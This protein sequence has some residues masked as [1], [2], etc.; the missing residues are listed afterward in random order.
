M[1]CANAQRY[2]LCILSASVL[3]TTAV[4]REGSMPCMILKKIKHTGAINDTVSDSNT[5]VVLIEDAVLCMT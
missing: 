2:V 5:T 1:R 4:L 3:T